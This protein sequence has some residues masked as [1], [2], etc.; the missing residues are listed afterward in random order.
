[1]SISLSNLRLPKQALPI[2]KNYVNIRKGQTN[3]LQS[4]V[5]STLKTLHVLKQTFSRRKRDIP[6]ARQNLSDT[7]KTWLGWMVV[8]LKRDNCLFRAITRILYRLFPAF[9]K[10]TEKQNQHLQYIERIQQL[11]TSKQEKLQELKNLQEMFEQPTAFSDREFSQNL[12]AHA[13]SVESL[14]NYERDI[15]DLS[16]QDIHA[17]VVSG[18]AW[19]GD[20]GREF[21]IICLKTPDQAFR[22]LLCHQKHL[23]PDCI[24]SDEP[25]GINWVVKDLL[26][27][28][29]NDEPFEKYL[30]KEGFVQKKFYQFLT[31]LL[32]HGRTP[33]TFK[34]GEENWFTPYILAT[35]EDVARLRERML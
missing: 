16:I 2:F 19:N 11:K 8:Q 23:S 31:D 10:E 7:Q 12:L 6:E 13:F 22:I 20:G 34:R 32:Q 35:V 33:W 18:V 30:V 3:E 17:P 1:M 21:V 14:P 24:L 15:E 29:P 28:N 27:A 25:K 26:E 5:E 9:R 4:K